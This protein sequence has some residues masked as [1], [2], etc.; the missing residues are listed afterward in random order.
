MAAAML[1]FNVPLGIGISQTTAFP[2]EA[3]CPIIQSTDCLMH[4]WH[5]MYCFKAILFRTLIKALTH[6]PMFSKQTT[7]QPLLSQKLTP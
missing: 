1:L 6:A 4:I 2:P 3:A 5:A 7:D